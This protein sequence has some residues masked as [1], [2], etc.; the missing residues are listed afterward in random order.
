MPSHYHLQVI[1]SACS[2]FAGKVDQ[3]VQ[4]HFKLGS[5]L[6]YSLHHGGGGITQADNS[7]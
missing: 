7:G 5:Q 6:S 3:S 1:P 2:K 4:A